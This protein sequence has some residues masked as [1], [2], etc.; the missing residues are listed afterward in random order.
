MLEKYF[1]HILIALVFIISLLSTC[2]FFL[3]R[4]QKIQKEHN[5]KL[6]QNAQEKEKY[7]LESLD[8]ITKAILQKQCELSE[9]CIRI[10]MLARSSKLLDASKEDYQ[11]FEKFYQDIKD[12][13]THKERAAL[14]ARKRMQEDKKRFHFED[15]YEDEFLKSTKTLFEEVKTL[16]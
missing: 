14:T 8:I 1:Y 4:K 6:K 9:G 5:D 13:K 16:L 15:F 11:I 12:L 10:R 3:L 7:I 2:I